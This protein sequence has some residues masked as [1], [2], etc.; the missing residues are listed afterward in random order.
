LTYK[1]PKKKAWEKY[2]E[3]KKERKLMIE[4]SEMTLEKKKNKM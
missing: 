2:K 1:H 3:R 4:E